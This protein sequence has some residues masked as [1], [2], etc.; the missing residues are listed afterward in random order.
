MYPVAPVR[1]T[2]KR[3]R[4]GSGWGSRVDCGRDLRCSWSWSPG[5]DCIASA[6]RKPRLNGGRAGPR[7]GSPEDGE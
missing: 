1:T 7:E 6:S 4:P 3:P 5:G 2:R